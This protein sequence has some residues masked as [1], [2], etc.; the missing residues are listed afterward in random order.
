MTDE[1]Q[2]ML[3]E[4]PLALAERITGNSYKDDP[5]T[6]ALGLFLHTHRSNMKRD[7]LLL[8]DDTFMSS[9]FEYALRVLE[10]EGFEII[11]DATYKTEAGRAERYLVL[12]SAGV[13]VELESYSGFLSD[14]RLP[15]VNKLNFYGNWM[16]NE[17]VNAFEFTSSGHYSR[18][19]AGFDDYP[20]GDER[21]ESDP[22]VW[23]GHWDG[24]EALRHKLAR[25]DANGTWLDEWRFDPWL[26]LHSYTEKEPR[27]SADSTWLEDRTLEKVV[28]FPEAICQNILAV[29]AKEKK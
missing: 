24:R 16:P 9:D 28:H 23:V 18:D 21:R 17:G 6:S 13:L 5:E 22:W 27:V 12:W 4:D 26:W 8:R 7:E 1:F 2:N 29:K 19:G 3:D 20:E 10:E 25:L 15:S 11:F 14:D